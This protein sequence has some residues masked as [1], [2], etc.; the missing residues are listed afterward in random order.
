MIRSSVGEFWVSKDTVTKAGKKKKNHKTEKLGHGVLK[1]FPK[2]L[3]FF[4]S[5][6]TTS[7]KVDNQ[8]WHYNPCDISD[9]QGNTKLYNWITLQSG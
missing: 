3:D 8:E 9:S 7:N 2:N 4:L 5:V 6:W 1:S